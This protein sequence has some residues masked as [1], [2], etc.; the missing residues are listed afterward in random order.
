MGTGTHQAMERRR[1]LAGTRTD[2]ELA[3]LWLA[4]HPTSTRA[5]YAGDLRWWR[6]RL[7]GEP[8]A[9]WRLRDLL[10][11]LEAEAASMAPAT[12]ARRVASIRSLLAFGRRVGVLGVDIGAVLRYR[13]AV[14]DALAERILEP[15]EVYRLLDAA[16]RAPRQGKRDH[17]FVRLAYVTG[18]RA[19]E[20][21]GLD[22][23]H[24][25]KN[26]D[27]SA[28]LTI[29]GK[30]GKTRHVWI[31]PKT[32]A[33]LEQ[34]RPRNERFKPRRDTGAIFRAYTGR[35]LSVRDAE[36]IIERAAKRAG[37]GR[38]SPH[39]LRHACA[40]HALEAGAPVHR[41]SADLGHSSVATTTRYLHARPGTGTA[42]WLGL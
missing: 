10:N 12:L 4:Q 30:G 24:V 36:R 17:L 20:L 25:H 33:E 42:Q 38:V 22:W 15:D 41:V 27:D 19:N 39:W 26:K 28:T 16:G 9:R 5:S 6:E 34:S 2:E 18:A 35:R 37:L 23:E 7:N 29:H 8:I 11:V 31:T 3:A 14:P 13:R 32:T 1:N 21:C 40:S